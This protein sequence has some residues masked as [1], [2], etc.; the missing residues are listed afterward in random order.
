MKSFLPEN[1]KCV[2]VVSPAGP[3]DKAKLESGISFLEK[4]GL[5]VKTYPGTFG[6]ANETKYLAAPDIRRAEEFTQAYLDEEV[7]MIFAARGGYGCSRM[8][9]Y[10]DWEKLKQF[11]KPVAGYSDLTSLFLAM[12]A[13]NC[14]TP[15]ASNMVS[16]LALCNERELEGIFAAVSGKKRSFSLDVIKSGRASGKIIAG[17]LTV[18]AR[19]AGTAFV[20]SAKGKILLLEDVGEAAY[21]IDRSLNQLRNCGFLPECSGLI[22]GYFSGAE[23]TEVQQVLK[24]YS[25]FIN[26][27]VLSGFAYGHEMPFDAVSFCQTAVINGNRLEIE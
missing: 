26:G 4:C 17:N 11:D 12:T 21:R 14:G 3:P 13:N 24:Y 20:P 1:I 5:K 10:L 23:E 22:T 9:P 16:E 6:I 2:A 27:P 15:V 7:D 25:S 19:C 18:A 8:L